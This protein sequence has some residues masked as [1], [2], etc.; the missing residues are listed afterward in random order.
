MNGLFNLE[1]TGD[2]NSEILSAP[3]MPRPPRIDKT[4]P[5]TPGGVSVDGV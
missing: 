3:V 1:S 4:I 5:D 2:R